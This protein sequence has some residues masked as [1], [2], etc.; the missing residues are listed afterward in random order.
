MRFSHFLL[1][2]SVFF[3]V[4][5]S[6]VS[7]GKFYELNDDVSYEFL[8]KKPLA[9][10]QT[11]VHLRYILSPNVKI[12]PVVLALGKY[13]VANAADGKVDSIQI[14]KLPL[15][16]TKAVE[17]ATRDL[18]QGRP[19]NA[20]P[21]GLGYQIV[22]RVP[23]GADIS[24]FDSLL[25]DAELLTSKE[26]KTALE[27]KQYQMVRPDI[28]GMTALTVIGAKPKGTSSKEEQLA[29]LEGYLSSLVDGFLLG[30][31]NYGALLFYIE[32]VHTFVESETQRG[33]RVGSE[34]PR[35]FVPALCLK[36]HNKMSAFDAMTTTLKDVPSDWANMWQVEGDEP[37]FFIGLKK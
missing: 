16:E 2:L 11:E 5:Y 25:K 28:E 23:K 9:E 13:Y 15:L 24:W 35:Y 3:C 27:A 19:V 17:E 32:G 4:V 29:H 8:A 36:T 14:L 37:K 22:F 18:Q 1:S 12:K 20:N 10:D 6:T 31:K 30:H 34:E 33:V 7:S 26:A 21:A